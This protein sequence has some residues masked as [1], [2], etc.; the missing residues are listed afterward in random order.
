[1]CVSYK[2]VA[3]PMTKLVGTISHILTTITILHNTRQSGRIYVCSSIFP[4][5]T[6]E[7]LSTIILLS[8]LQ[9]SPMT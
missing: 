3:L 4:F 6:L 7:W 2:L 1:M 9:Q 5:S 8:L